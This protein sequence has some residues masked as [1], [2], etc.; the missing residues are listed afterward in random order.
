MKDEKKQWVLATKRWF[1]GKRYYLM[2]KNEEG[3]T[4]YSLRQK[5]AIRFATKQKA[6]EYLKE[7]AFRDYFPTK[8]I[9]NVS[10]LSGYQIGYERGLKAAEKKLLENAS[11]FFS[12]LINR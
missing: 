12:S 8:L 11:F 2:P 10:S 6:A 1:G 3:K 7:L 9:D 5:Q 4:A